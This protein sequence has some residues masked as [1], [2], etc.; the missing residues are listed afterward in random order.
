[1]TCLRKIWRKKPAEIQPRV[2]FITQV[3]GRNN[4]WLASYMCRPLN[5][6]FILKFSKQH[7]YMYVEMYN[8]R[9]KSVKKKKNKN[10]QTNLID[11]YSYI[12]EEV[13]FGSKCTRLWLMH[14]VINPD[15]YSYC[16]QFSSHVREIFPK[17]VN[18]CT[19]SMRILL[20]VNRL[21]V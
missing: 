14:F 16:N 10:P 12:I 11:I 2:S 4:S 6:I 21:T 18:T 5:F 9:E 17:F 8:Y 3:Q 1:M 13:K 19:S 7:L 15:Y 20:A